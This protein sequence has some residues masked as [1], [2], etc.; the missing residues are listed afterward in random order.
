MGERI[1]ESRLAVQGVRTAES[2]TLPSTVAY[3]PPLPTRN[4][5][6]WV[7]FLTC[8]PECDNLGTTFRW[9]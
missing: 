2:G 5:A 1:Y 4:N 9:N 3:I 8:H 6:G 7:W